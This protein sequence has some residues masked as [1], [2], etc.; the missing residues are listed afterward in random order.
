MVSNPHLR[1][2]V[3]VGLRA[4]RNGNTESAD[5]GRSLILLPL[6]VTS[7]G[8]PARLGRGFGHRILT[9]TVWHKVSWSM[10]QFSIILFR[11]GISVQLIVRIVNCQ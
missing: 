10:F 8:G 1:H 11:C 7:Y 6:D 2:S 9:P 5:E 4:G 3:F